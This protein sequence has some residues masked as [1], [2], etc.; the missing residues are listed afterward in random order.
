MDSPPCNLSESRIFARILPMVFLTQRSRV[1]SRKAFFPAWRLFSAIPDN[2][3]FLAKFSESSS[4]MTNDKFSMTN[5]QFRLSPLV[6]A[7]PAKPWRLCVERSSLSVSSPDSESGWFN[8]FGGGW[9]RCDLCVL[10]GNNAALPSSLVH[11]VGNGGIPACL[12]GFAAPAFL[13]PG[14]I[15]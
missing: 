8:S 6:A 5:S 4:Q 7:C 14:I 13:T 15:P 1:Q 9:P 2:C 3:A 12:T 11:I 10:C